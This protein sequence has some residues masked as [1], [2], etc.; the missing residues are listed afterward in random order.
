MAHW[1]PVRDAGWE[2]SRYYN[3]VRKPRATI[4][5]SAGALTIVWAALVLAQA[6][7]PPSPPSPFRLLWSVALEGSPTAPPTF[8]DQRGFFSMD[9]NR[10]VA[11]DLADGAEVWRVARSVTLQP[12]AGEGLL[13]VVEPGALVALREA[14][15]S[16]AWERSFSETLSAPLVCDNGWLVAAT[17]T[18]TVLAFRATDGE[19]IWRREIGVMASARPALAADRVYV[20]AANGRVI[21]MHVESGKPLW[22]RRLGG[23]PDQLL[24]LE[25]R[26]YVGADDNYLYCI[27][28]ENGLV[29]WRWATGADVVGLPVADDQRVFFISLDNVLRGLDRR[30]GNQRWKRTLPLRP[31]SGPVRSGDTLI[32]SGIAPMLRVYF[33]KDGAPAGEMAADG[34]LA[35]APYALPEAEAPTV[36]VVTRNIEKGAMLAS[37]SRVAAPAPAAAPAKPTDAAPADPPDAVPARPPDA[38]PAAPP[39]P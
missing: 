4:C 39:P 2:I 24:A 16:V 14:D 19:L 28:A 27:T 21:A 13:F 32:V 29:D 11:R 1:G 26:L 22:E 23:K 15:G 25:D 12:A 7:P 37:F 35:S 17:T 8:V 3:G 6:P 33:L 20:P 9:D 5:C 36:L 31:L 38:K 30:T 10:L 18:G 34:E